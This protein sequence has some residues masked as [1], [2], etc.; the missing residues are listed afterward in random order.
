MEALTAKMASRLPRLS[1]GDYLAG[2]QLPMT[3]ELKK[4]I[5]GCKDG[6]LPSLEGMR[7]HH[8]DFLSPQQARARKEN[9]LTGSARRR[10]GR[11]RNAW[12]VTIGQNGVV[13]FL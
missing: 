5:V 11:A 13:I 9:F 4:M 6:P 10:A 2:I 3:P 7:W 12:A 8:S 1:D